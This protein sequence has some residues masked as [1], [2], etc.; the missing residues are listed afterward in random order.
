MPLPPD[1]ISVRETPESPEDPLGLFHSEN[2][3]TVPTV[4]HAPS[5]RVH[6][7]R[8]RKPSKIA[9]FSAVI[10]TASRRAVRFTVAARAGAVFFVQ[11][12]R[13]PRLHVPALRLPSWRLP[14]WRLP[15][16]QL[17]AWTDGA[18]H[19]H[20][21]SVISQARPAIRRLT[22]RSSL[23]TVTLSAFACGTIVGGSVM[24][25]AG[26]SR[27]VVI[28]STAPQQMPRQVPRPAASPGAPVAPAFAVTPVVQNAPSHTTAPP[29]AAA[30]I[31]RPQFRGSLVVNSRPS[32]ARVFVNGRGVGETPLVLR[33]QLAGSRA[34]RVALDGYEPWSSAV[35]VVADTETQ[36]RAEL[37]IQRPVQP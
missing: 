25:L 37:K 27:Q 34:I 21:A 5:V 31:R 33:N 20:L 32:G 6:Y 10:V 26:A 12:L 9:S 19:G 18:W 4:P 35:R 16:W 28:E 7:R 2:Q 29:T 17:P 15:A 3:K 13:R 22:A 24:W 1:S 11:G 8:R 30:S 14:R 36:L 23:S